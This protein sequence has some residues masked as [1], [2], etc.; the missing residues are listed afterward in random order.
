M[1]GK[2]TIVS[3][4][5]TLYQV[6]LELGKGF[7]PDRI[8][9]LTTRIA[10]LTV[11]LAGL[12]PGD[13]H[14]TIELQIA[15]LTRQKTTLEAQLPVNPTV[16]AWCVDNTTDLSPGTVVGTIEVP[17]ERGTVNIRPGFYDGAAYDST[18]DGLLKPIVACETAEAM[19][20]FAIMP[21]WQKWQPTYRY[22]LI[23][24]IN[25][26]LNTVSLVMQAATSSMQGLNVNQT[27]FLYNVP[28]V[29]MG[30]G[31]SAFS[32]NDEVVVEFINQDWNNPQVIGFKSDPGQ[33]AFHVKAVRDYD[34]QVIGPGGSYDL[35]SN[36]PA[37]IAVRADFTNAIIFDEYSGN[38][39]WNASTEEWY[40][41]GDETDPDPNGYWLFCYPS[42]SH[43]VPAQY[44]NVYYQPSQYDTDD[45][46]SYGQAGLVINLPY[47]YSELVKYGVTPYRGVLGTFAND[48]TWTDY[49]KSV[50][51]AIVEVVS[52]SLDNVSADLVDYGPIGNRQFQRPEWPFTTT[53]RVTSSIPYTVS[54]NPLDPYPS[55]NPPQIVDMGGYWQ[56]LQNPQGDDLVYDLV[57]D[58]TGSYGAS[59]SGGRLHY[60]KKRAHNVTGSYTVGAVYYSPTG[61]MGALPITS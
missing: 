32:I 25:D 4:I 11:T 16:S 3:N 59:G 49:E 41:I 60:V 36:D 10:E 44:P 30:A 51:A 34:G 48:G 20:N 31:T 61:I 14:D 52:S 6:T 39:T 37:F 12:P 13:E 17:G 47:F 45:L 8:T 35:F 43:S 5:G 33:A 19:F 22:A 38:M 26:E 29:Y 2:G 57:D 27:G 53:Y 7:M 15:A 50:A 56:Y 40:L 55:S 23:T 46:V 28:V 42:D 1:V 54:T 58:P 18:R 9:T 24:G 21:G